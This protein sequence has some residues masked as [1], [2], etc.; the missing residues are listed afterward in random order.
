MGDDENVMASLPADWQDRENQ[1]LR[2]WS[3]QMAIASGATTASS[4]VKSASLIYDYVKGTQ[5]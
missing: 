1:E 3:V 4:A 5:A 2:R